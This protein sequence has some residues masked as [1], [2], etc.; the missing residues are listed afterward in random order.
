[1]DKQ[2]LKFIEET[3]IVDIMKL[4]YKQWAIDNWYMINKDYE[5]EERTQDS[6]V[7]WV[8]IEQK[9]VTLFC[10]QDN[11]YDLSE[12]IIDDWYHLLN[13]SWYD[14]ML[15]VQ[16]GWEYEIQADYVLKSLDDVL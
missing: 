7:D 16:R 8:I 2:K 6:K 10:K 13:I 4:A 9:R 11:Y 5:M 15:Q 1:M 14:E 3:G 12:A